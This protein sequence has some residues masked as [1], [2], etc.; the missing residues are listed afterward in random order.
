[1][2][3][4]HGRHLREEAYQISSRSD[5]KR[6]SIIGRNKNK[7]KMSSDIR[8]V[9]DLKNAATLT[10]HSSIVEDMHGIIPLPWAATNEATVVSLF[11]VIFQTLTPGLGN[12]K[13]IQ[14]TIILGS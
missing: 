10:T 8:S 14:K 11:I 6:Q 5:L 9:T 3:W 13:R 12:R 1:M 2:K 4:R 7:E